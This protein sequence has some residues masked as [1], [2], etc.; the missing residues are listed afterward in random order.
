LVTPSNVWSITGGKK[1]TELGFSRT[2][3]YFTDFLNQEKM[4]FADPFSNL[5]L[6]VETKFIVLLGFNQVDACNV[7][8]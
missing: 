8:Q 2:S 3:L 4:G 1:G 7:Q 6:M 5:R